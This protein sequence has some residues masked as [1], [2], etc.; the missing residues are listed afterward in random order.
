MEF[1]IET[2]RPDCTIGFTQHTVAEALQG[3]NLTQVYRLISYLQQE[4]EHFLDAITSHFSLLPF[5][6]I[7]GKS[8]ATGETV[9]E[10][11]YQAA[12]PASCMVNVQQQLADFLQRHENSESAK[13]LS[14]TPLA[15]SMRFEGPYLELWVHYSMPEK[16]LARSYSMNIIRICHGSLI[17][18]I[19]GFLTDLDRLMGWASD[20][21]LRGMA[22]QLSELAKH[23]S[24]L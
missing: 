9:F 10:A 24:G 1:F 7:D 22:D 8:Y 5:L 18:G 13:K 3:L 4:S 17:Y 6:A 21:V 2:S 19:T 14:K 15:F 12:V 11:Q 20:E 16:N 23:V